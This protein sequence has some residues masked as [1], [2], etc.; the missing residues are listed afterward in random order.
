[1]LGDQL[2]LASSALAGRDPETATVL[3]V[4]SVSRAV[5]RPYHK[6]KLVLM[7]SAM[8]HFADELR[9]LG[10]EVDYYELAPSMRDGLERHVNKHRPSRLHIMESAEHGA[11]ASLAALATNAGVECEHLLNTLFIS[12]RAAFAKRYRGKK[13]VLLEGFYRSMRRATGLLMDGDEPAGGQWNYDKDNRDVPERGH[14]FPDIP[15][16]EPDATTRRVMR[17]VSKRFASHFGELEG[18]AWPLTRRDAERFFEDFLDQRLDRFGPYED[19]MVSGEPALYHSLLSPLLHIGLLDPLDVCRRAEVRYREGRARLNSVEGFIRQILGWREFVYQIYH[20]Q[21]PGY[22]ECNALGADV[23]LPDL[24]WTG[25]TSMRCVGEAVD[26]L[27]RNGTN[28]HIQRLMVTGNFALIAGLDPREVNEWYW[29]AHVDAFEWVV[30]P[31]VLGLTLYADGGLLAT[32]P[33]AASANYLHK[34]SDYCGSCEYDRKRAKGEGS[35]PFNAFYW[36]FL[37]RHRRRFG[38]NPRMNLVMAALRKKKPAELK[39]IRRRARE[40]RER[41]RSGASV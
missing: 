5:R 40:L 35:C 33:Y 15:K 34:M 11:S 12:D 26:Q 9:S 1:V 3:M 2:T 7:W 21:M 18:F 20:W 30:S 38:K 16:F 22:T 6:Q 17:Q 36:N 8:R 37:A 29:L 24:Y 4:E 13:S 39:A 23:P 19:A 27:R 25:E 28:H 41:L 14:R 32:K 31:N 10:Y